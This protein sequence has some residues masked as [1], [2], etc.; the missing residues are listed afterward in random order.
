MNEVADKGDGFVFEEEGTKHAAME[1]RSE[2]MGVVRERR[3][4]GRSVRLKI[5]HSR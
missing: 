2:L 4:Q 1:L 5:S 3:P